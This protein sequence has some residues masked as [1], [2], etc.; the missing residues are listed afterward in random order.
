MIELILKYK[1]VFNQQE[2]EKMNYFYIR[3][4]NCEK[5]IE[6]IEKDII[7]YI[8][9]V[10]LTFEEN[11]EPETTLIQLLKKEEIS[12]VDRGKIIRNTTTIISDLNDI[13]IEVDSIKLD[14]ILL[15]EFKVKPTWGNIYSH[16]L[17]TE[18]QFSDSLVIFLNKLDNAESLSLK[19][20][21]I[22]N[23]EENKE[24]QYKLITENKISDK[25]YTLLLK[26]VS[27][28]FDELDFKELSFEKARLLIENKIVTLNV[29][30]YNSLK[31]SFA[32]LII[33]FIESQVT[34]FLEDITDFSL[35]EKDVVSILKSKVLNHEELKVIVKFTS[36][37]VSYE[38]I[39]YFDALGILL[40]NA[41]DFEVN[42]TFANEILTKSQ[43][44]TENKIKLFI[45]YTRLYTKE[46]VLDFLNL[47]PAPYSEIENYYSATSRKRKK[48]SIKKT[49]LNIELI[50]KLVMF[51]LINKKYEDGENFISISVNRK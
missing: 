42:V 12:I 51:G 44:S 40:I 31:E 45:N 49:E 47:L 26:S 21:D 9:D 10:Y 3:G 25:C 19:K 18:N 5:L 23:T 37:S 29:K 22:E 14:E 6:Y 41:D 39:E 30:S 16:Y 8:K 24:F 46:Q 43:L 33:L 35:D 32:K 38:G 34:N 1:N 11:Q 50:D 20:I 48:V 13:D 7:T 28:I 17:N 36:Q 4:T 2:F 15:E 27:L